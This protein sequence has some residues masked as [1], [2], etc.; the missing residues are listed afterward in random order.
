MAEGLQKLLENLQAEIN[1]LRSH[2]SSGRPT[3][4]KDFSLISLI[5]GWSGTEK[6]VSVREFSEL[7]ESSA[8]IGCWS[9]FDRIQITIL[10]HSD[11]AKVF[12]SSKP[13]LQK[14]DI[15][16]ENFKSKHLHRIRDVTSDQYHFMKLQ[17]AR[18]K[19]DETTRIFGSVSL[20]SHENYP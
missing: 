4:P 17:R 3:E 1:N 13:E 2:V 7:V 14:T 16:W 6:S 18:Q 12:Y 8:R 19:K 5:P 10:K 20:I 11:V 15:S 9:E